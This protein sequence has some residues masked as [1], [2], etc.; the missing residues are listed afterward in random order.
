MALLVAAIK[1][2]ANALVPSPQLLELFEVILD[3]VFKCGIAFGCYF[4]AFPMPR[5]TPMWFFQH[6]SRNLLKR[7][8]EQTLRVRPTK[9]FQPD[10]GGC[11]SQ[12]KVLTEKHVC[13]W[14]HFK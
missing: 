10:F 7:T 14:T 8:D 11:A 1:L 12:R 13:V 4:A 9:D 6:R 3:D 5:L 2:N